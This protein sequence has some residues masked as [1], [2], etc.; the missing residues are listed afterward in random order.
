M[1]VLEALKERRAVRIV[2]TADVIPEDE[3]SSEDNEY[4]AE[5][6]TTWL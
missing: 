1:S 6:K 4:A 2:V 5:N 3:A